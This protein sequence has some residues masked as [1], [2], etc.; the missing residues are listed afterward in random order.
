MNGRQFILTAVAYALCSLVSIASAAEQGKSQT[1]GDRSL[2]ELW[3]SGQP[4]F[5]Q[6]VTQ[7]TQAKSD[8]S[9]AVPA[10]YTVQTGLDLAA[11]PLLD[12][13]FLSLEQHYDADSA[14]D[15]A[16]GIG[17]HGADHALP[18]L[19][20][21]PPISVDGV[22]AARARVK[23][24]VAM[25]AN[26][27]VIPH[28]LTVEEARTAV[29]FFEGVDVWSPTN[30]EGDIVAM[31]IIEDP[32][33]FSDL[34][35]IANIPGYSALV[36]GIG[37]LTS[38]LGGD[39]EAAEAINMQVLAESKRAGKPNLTTVSTESVARRVDQGFLALLAYGSDSNEAI[40]LGRR[41]AGR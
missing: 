31:L 25:G 33:V 12:F 34:E 11:N 16:K 36:C 26:G 22:D 40:R 38:A 17:A 13:A 9:S 20:R 19:V 8:D 5:G 6:Y 27:V 24:L 21:I 28:V 18:L 23:E 1:V 14:R 7:H 10:P 30:P 4:A 3:E 37:S 32:D 2:I 29:S 39:R 35:E 15:V 41:A